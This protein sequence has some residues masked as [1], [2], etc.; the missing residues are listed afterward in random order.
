[1][2]CLGIRR[3][4]MQSVVG[5]GHFQ[6]RSDSVVS[7]SVVS[8]SA[9]SDSAVSDSVVSHITISYLQT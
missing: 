7:D 9:V 5:F 3:D 2:S 6:R 4:S 8:D 1:M